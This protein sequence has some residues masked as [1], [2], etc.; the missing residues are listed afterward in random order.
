MTAIAMIV[1]GIHERFEPA[2]PESAKLAPQRPATLLNHLVGAGKERLVLGRG[3]GLKRRGRGERPRFGR[4]AFDDW[5][6]G[7]I[8]APA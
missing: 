6:N 3:N 4:T 2:E 7:R 1:A 8:G 5:L